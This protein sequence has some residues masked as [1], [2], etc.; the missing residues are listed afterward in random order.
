M[1]LVH[2]GRRLCIS[3]PECSERLLFVWKDLALAWLGYVWA[4]M[5]WRAR[6]RS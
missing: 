3:G 1:R 6:G 5:E 4:S 2:V